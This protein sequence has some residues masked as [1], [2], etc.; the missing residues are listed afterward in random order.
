MGVKSPAPP[1]VALF[2]LLGIGIDEQG[3]IW[4]TPA[5]PTQDDRAAR[6][7][8]AKGSVEAPPGTLTEE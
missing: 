4:P 5:A 8:P 6:H 1:I 3:V 2:G 7:R